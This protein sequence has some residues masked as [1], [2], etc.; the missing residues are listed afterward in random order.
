[1]LR[2]TLAQEKLYRVPPLSPS[3]LVSAF[4]DKMID[5]NYR[6]WRDKTEQSFPR[7]VRLVLE[8][9]EELG[10][11]GDPRRAA[12]RCVLDRHW[13]PLYLRCGYCILNH[14]FVGRLENFRGT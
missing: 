7:F 8:Q 13:K 14:G 2:A 3:R 12:R 5:H 9:A 11:M 10:C 1:M 6:G 4:V